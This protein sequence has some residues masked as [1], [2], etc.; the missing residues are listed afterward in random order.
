[1]RSIF[2]FTRTG[3]ERPTSPTL[4]ENG[5]SLQQRMF[6]AVPAVSEGYLYYQLPVS[7]PGGTVLIVASTS[8]LP[9]TD[10]PAAGSLQVYV[11]ANNATDAASTIMYPGSSSG[12]HTW[13]SSEDAASGRQTVT[14]TSSAS[15]YYIAIGMR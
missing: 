5:V 8:A 10:A 9:I 15:T 12:Q 13:S 11:T 2:T 4:L 1:M 3:L 7:T 14:V 6:P